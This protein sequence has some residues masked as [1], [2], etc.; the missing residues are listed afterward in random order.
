MRNP[1]GQSVEVHLSR[2]L[3]KYAWRKILHFEGLTL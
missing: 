2:L 1:K 3:E